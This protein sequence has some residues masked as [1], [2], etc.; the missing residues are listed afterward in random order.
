MISGCTEGSESGDMRKIKK[1][2]GIGQKELSGAVEEF[3]RH[4]RLKN[5]SPHTIEYY[6]E[7]L[8]YFQKVSPIRYVDEFTSQVM[9]DFVDH[10]MAKGNSISAI[11]TRIRGLRVFL[12]FCADREYAKKL[13]FPLLKEDEHLKEPYTDAELHRLV[14]R[15]TSDYW[16]EWRTWAAINTFLATGIRANSIVN[17]KI[18]DVDFEHDTLALRTDIMPMPPRGQ[19]FLRIGIEE[20]N[21]R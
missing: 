17:I 7:D 15:P 19:I 12:N 11:N 10:E 1:V 9:E 14:K 8:R 20:V 21:E 6:S 13:T 18:C 4:C 16:G 5:L 2:D 3:I